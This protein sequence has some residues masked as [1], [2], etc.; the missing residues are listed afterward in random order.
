MW[1]RKRWDVDEH[2]SEEEKKMDE[3]AVDLTISGGGGGG[4]VDD[5]P[6]TSMIYDKRHDMIKRSTGMDTSSLHMTHVYTSSLHLKA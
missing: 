4:I 2:M 5:E 3:V 6:V 1:M